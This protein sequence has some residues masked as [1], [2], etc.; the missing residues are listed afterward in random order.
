LKFF[1]L[2]LLLGVV[3]LDLNLGIK[4][5]LDICASGF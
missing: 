2:L 5:C 3:T 4:N 1:L